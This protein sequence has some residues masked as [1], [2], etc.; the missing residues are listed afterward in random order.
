MCI[1][2]IMGN[3]TQGFWMTLNLTPHLFFLEEETEPQGGEITCPKVTQP[4]YDIAMEKTE[5]F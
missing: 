5:A 1:C 4:V 3:P 2:E